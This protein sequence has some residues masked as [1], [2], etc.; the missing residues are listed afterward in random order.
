MNQS[1]DFRLS[2]TKALGDQL[3]AA[4]TKLTPAPLAVGN[5]HKLAPRSGVYQLHY[6]DELIYIGKAE[7]PLPERLEQHR[8]KISGR[9]NIDVSDVRFVCLYVDEDF[10]AVAPEKLLIRDHTGRGE[11]SWNNNGFGNNDPGRQRDATIV[12]PGHFDA[13]Y[14]V[15]LELVC[16]IQPGHYTGAQLAGELKEKLPYLFRYDESP[17]LASIRV[18]VPTAPM[19]AHELFTLLGEAVARI[20]TKGARWQIV[21][22]PGRIIM[23]RDSGTHYA[24]A[25]YAYP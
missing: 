13:L 4:L 25:L 15:H 11:A 7:R 8:R 9:A 3:A 19:T 1:A 5:I 6:L 18:D 21:A 22:L 20:P 23:Y 10:H 14:P 16:D 12:K 17:A 2:I 24:S